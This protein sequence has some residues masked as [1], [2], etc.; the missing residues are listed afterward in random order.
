VHRSPNYGSLE[1]FSAAYDTGSWSSELV[2]GT[3]IVS[4]A[5]VINADS[6]DGHNG[7][8]TSV[9]GPEGQVLLDHSA[10]G[11]GTWYGE[12]VPGSGSSLLNPG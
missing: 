6:F 7:V 12:T 5:P 2:S 3:N 1:F 10:F 11:S 9:I 4:S 8:N